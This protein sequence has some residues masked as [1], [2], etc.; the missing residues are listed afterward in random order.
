MHRIGLKLISTSLLLFALSCAGYRYTQT[1]NP[2]QQYGVESL[3]IPMF[4][5]FSSLPEVSSSFTRETYK[6]LSGF[7]GLK[8]SSGY[9]RNADAVLIGIVR[10]P[11]KLSEVLRA[12]T[13]RVAQEVAPEALGNDR[14]E[15]YVPGSTIVSLA[16]QV[17]VVKRPTEEELSLLKSE[18]GQKLPAQGKILFNE[19]FTINQAFTREIFDNEATSVVGTQNAGALRRTKESMAVTA[20][21]QIRDMILYAF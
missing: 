1:S 12:D 20:A 19:T 21:E 4:Y 3:S 10:S 5:N 11:E 9:N 18:L 7:S 13:P 15:F 14:P 6:L 16:L 8:L 17:I 2:L